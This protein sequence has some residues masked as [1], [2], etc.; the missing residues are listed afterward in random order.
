[1]KVEIYQKQAQFGYFGLPGFR[2]KEQN[3]KSVN[4]VV[5]HKKNRLMP[6]IKISCQR[7]WRGM[8]WN[9]GKTSKI[10][11]NRWLFPTIENPTQR[12]KSVLFKKKFFCDW[13][14]SIETLMRA[15]LQPVAEKKGFVFHDESKLIANFANF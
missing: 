12:M 8:S 13:N 9:I 5:Y 14:L 2:R 11:P 7:L 4:R 3:Q 1:M 6:D 15:F 10:L